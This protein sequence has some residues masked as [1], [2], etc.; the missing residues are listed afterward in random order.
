MR[1]RNLPDS[2]WYLAHIWAHKR[3]SVNAGWT[4]RKKGGW[5]QKKKVK[6]SWYLSSSMMIMTM[7]MIARVITD[8]VVYYMPVIVSSTLH[9]MYMYS[10]P[11]SPQS[12]EVCIFLIRYLR[13]QNH[14]LKPP[15][16]L[17]SE[18]TFP[19]SQFKSFCMLLP[20]MSFQTSQH[21]LSF[22][23]NNWVKY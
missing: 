21:F 12:Y 18:V 16:L 5:E 14:W 22:H 11:P 4:E 20:V 19:R 7:V 3:H 15:R 17:A 23:A 10:S 9:A 8:W 2:Y 1:T 6:P 13:S